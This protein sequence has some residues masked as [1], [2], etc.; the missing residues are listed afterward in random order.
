VGQKAIDVGK[1]GN[2]RSRLAPSLPS[3]VVPTGQVLVRAPAAAVTG[4]RVWILRAYVTEARGPKSA[5]SACIDKDYKVVAGGAIPPF[6]ATLPAT[7]GLD[8]RRSFSVAPATW[9]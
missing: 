4:F 2:K 5:C 8:A 6:G 3:P 1:D 9:L 7:N